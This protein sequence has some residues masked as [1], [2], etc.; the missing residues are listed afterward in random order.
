MFKDE[1]V[2]DYGPHGDAGPEFLSAYREI[3]L[4]L[5]RKQPLG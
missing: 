5:A 1:A 2:L 3:S 4:Q